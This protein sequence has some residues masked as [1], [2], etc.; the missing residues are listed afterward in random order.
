MRFLK[1]KR[2]RKAAG[3][4][5]RRLSELSGVKLRTIQNWEYGVTVPTILDF[6]KVADALGCKVD[7]LI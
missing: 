4:T 3:L 6:K 5:Q 1:L 7:D 2:A